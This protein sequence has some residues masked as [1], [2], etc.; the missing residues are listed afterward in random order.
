M[1][2]PMGRR[3]DDNLGNPASVEIAPKDQP[4]SEGF[5]IV[6]VGFRKHVAYPTYAEKARSAFILA[7]KVC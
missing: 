7:R 4:S 2:V 5:I 6:V 3:G 1:P